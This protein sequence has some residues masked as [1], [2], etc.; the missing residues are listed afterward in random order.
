MVHHSC[1]YRENDYDHPLLGGFKRK[2]TVVSVGTDGHLRCSECGRKVC[3]SDGTTHPDDDGVPVVEG[4]YPD[5][6]CS[7]RPEVATATPEEV[8]RGDI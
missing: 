4:P 3:F 5:G 6:W 1:S 7:D 8:L 2:P